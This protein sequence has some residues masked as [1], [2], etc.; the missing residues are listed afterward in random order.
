MA[1]DVRD[2]RASPRK[3]SPRSMFPSFCQNS[4]RCVRVSD[5]AWGSEDA[6]GMR[7]CSSTSEETPP[8]LRIATRKK[9]SKTVN[10]GQLVRMMT[11]LGL[12]PREEIG[13]CPPIPG[14]VP[15]STPSVDTQTDGSSELE[16]C[17][18]P[19]SPSRMAIPE[20]EQVFRKQSE[21]KTG[22]LAEE[23]QS[24]SVIYKQGCAH[25]HNYKKQVSYTLRP[26]TLFRKIW[27]SLYLLFLTVE[28]TH[29][30]IA[31]TTLKDSGEF[32]ALYT[33]WFISCKA[34]FSLFW[35]IDIYLQVCGVTFFF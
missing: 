1:R 32:S 33:D 11:S 18:P 13:K 2:G 8:Q 14:K 7:R 23:P 35:A 28:T 16:Q 24:R 19:A 5:Q 3:G 29:W 12:Q 25:L 22:I 27:D 31:I 30:L 9:K 10:E 15:E 6:G 34:L 20:H 4:P 21:S 17:D 26:D